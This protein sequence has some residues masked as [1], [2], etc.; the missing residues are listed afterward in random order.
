MDNFKKN[1]ILL[2]KIAKEKKYAQEYLGLL[3]RRG[4]IGSIR[5]GKRWYT[6][7]E[8]FAEFEKDA[9]VKK[10]EMKVAEKIIEAANV[11]VAIKKQEKEKVLVAAPAAEKER[12]NEEKISIIN[13]RYN[14]S[15]VDQKKEEVAIK[16]SRPRIEK[17]LPTINLREK[18]RFQAPKEKY[19]ITSKR[20]TPLA[21]EKINIEKALEKT[22]REEFNVSNKAKEFLPSFSPGIGEK[23]PFFPKLAFGASFALLLLLLL[24]VGFVFKNDIA[25]MVGFRVGSVAGASDSRLGL[26][27]LKDSSLA[28]LEG[29]EGATKENISLS[30]VLVKAAIEKENSGNQGNNN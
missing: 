4:D 12:K 30:R 14:T 1:F 8:W 9:K 20:P 28:Y 13:F 26:L 18:V 29:Q 23:M 15:P 3:A 25:G 22:K 7:A 2:S 24:Q 11:A 5:I 19:S 10:A 6:T 17:K 27:V 21:F 16:I